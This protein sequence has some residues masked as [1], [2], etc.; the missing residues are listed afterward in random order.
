MLLVQA[1]YH[2]ERSGPVPALE[3][4][5]CVCMCLCCAC[6]LPTTAHSISSG[7]FY[8]SQDSVRFGGV[9]RVGGDDGEG[10]GVVVESCLVCVCV[11]VVCGE[12]GGGGEGVMWCV[13]S[14]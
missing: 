1:S 9:V 3:M 13:C 6:V 11:H 8:T 7:V 14:C 4:E 10:Q 12:G 2:L 5:M